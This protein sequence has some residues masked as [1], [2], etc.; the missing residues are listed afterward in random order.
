MPKVESKFLGLQMVIPGC[1][2]RTLPKS[3]SRANWSG[4][5][6]LGFYAEPTLRDVLVHRT[7]APLKAKKRQKGQK[8]LAM[9][10]LFGA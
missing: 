2:A 5:G 7:N 4:Q 8:G 10:G 9:C 1:E 6:L 3:A